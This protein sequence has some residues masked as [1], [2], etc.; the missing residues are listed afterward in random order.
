MKT[1]YTEAAPSRAE[2]D[3]FPGATL[4]EFGTNWC[5]YCRAAQPLLTTAMETHGEL[6]HIKVEDG[7]GRALGRSFRVKLWPT[8]IFMRDG[9]EVSRLVRPDDAGSI[10][11]ALA[12]IDP[13]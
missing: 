5:G 8:M 13:S 6:R 3:A 11:Q 1:V 4:V 10:E 9:Q 7:P 12:Q 2:L